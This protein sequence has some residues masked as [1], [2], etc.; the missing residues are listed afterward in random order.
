MRNCKI[1]IWTKGWL[2][3]TTFGLGNLK[4]NP[5]IEMVNNHVE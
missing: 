4:Y 3:S 1:A 2:G 5:V